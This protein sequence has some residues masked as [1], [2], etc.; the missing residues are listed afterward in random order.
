MTV[1]RHLRVPAQAGTS[2]YLAE[3]VRIEIF[4][5]AGNHGL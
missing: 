3:R 4:A 2:F 1:F 5:F